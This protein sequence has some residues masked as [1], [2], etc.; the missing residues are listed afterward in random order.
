MNI[1][2]INNK[3][4][5][6]KTTT[7]VNLAAALARSGSRVLLIDLDSQ[8]S[9][10]LSLG[11]PR[12]DLSPSTAHLLFGSMGAEQVIRESSVPELDLLSGEMNLASADL[13]LA[14][15]PGRELRLSH[16]L[17][18][19]RRRYDFIL[20]DCPPSLSMLSINALVASDR[21]MVPMTAEYLALEGLI[22][23]MNG[24]DRMKQGM[25]L[26]AGLLGIV[27]TMVNPCL[28]IT[29][30]IQSL[31]RDHYGSLV[32]ETEIRRDVKLGEAP[33]YGRS[34]FQHAANSRGADAY[35]MLAKEVR[36]R[37]GTKGKE[38]QP[39]RQEGADKDES[40]QEQEY[41]PKK[42]N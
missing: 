42:E 18:G 41:E 26:R 22:G 2:V 21:F 27:F 4:G 5:T 31:I 13:M 19:V 6:G 36:E 3:G 7:C 12:N 14:D 25:G 20:F 8:A 29:E 37:C 10:S 23:L 33:A 39:A 40:I 32:F 35:S 34:I 15:V 28:K 9:A 16:G 17:A 1:A 24:I 30:E 11:V 38:V